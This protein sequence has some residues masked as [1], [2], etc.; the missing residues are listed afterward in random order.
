MKVAY[1]GRLLFRHRR[2]SFWPEEKT[3]RERGRLWY[4]AFLILLGGFCAGLGVPE[5]LR[6]GDGSYAG[7][8]SLYSF[9]TFETSS[10]SPEILFPY[11]VRIRMM[12]HQFL[13][14]SSYTAAGLLFHFLW[15][16]WL[17]SSAGLLLA[18]FALRDGYEGILLFFCC[19]FPQ[20][21][22]YGIAWKMEF[23]FLFCQWLER[24]PSDERKIR[25]F[26]RKD[27]AGLSR[28]IILILLGC[29]AETFVGMWTI[30]IFL[31]FFT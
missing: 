28:M 26:R 25:E 14:M 31:Q 12:T 24:I 3:G 30:K 5:L 9:H 2:E 18:L 1:P 22:L 19:L 13:W 27:L 29:A 8:A 6:M 20:W 7:Y 10:I 4:L 11:L 17:G 21:V 15:L 16:L 23:R